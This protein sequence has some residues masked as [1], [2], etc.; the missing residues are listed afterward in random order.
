MKKCLLALLAVIFVFVGCEGDMPEDE[1]ITY[2][3]AVELLEEIDDDGRTKGSCDMIVSSSHC[4]DYVGSFWTEEQ[5]KYACEGSG[6]LS[7]NQ[8]CPYSEL[9]GCRA[10]GGL[11]TENI[12]WYYGYGGMPWSDEEAMYSAMACN[13]LD[14]SDWVYPEF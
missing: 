12:I 13:A 9:G 10:T 7:L 6:T 3:D 11:I 4:L 8:T 14:V 2:D 5:M 1:D